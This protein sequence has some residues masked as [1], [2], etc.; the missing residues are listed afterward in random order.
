METKEDIGKCC[1]ISVT[2]KPF[3]EDKDVLLVNILSVSIAEYRVTCASFIIRGRKEKENILS[4][5]CAVMVR[6]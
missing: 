4:T 2:I 5:N 1:K 3:L 6:V